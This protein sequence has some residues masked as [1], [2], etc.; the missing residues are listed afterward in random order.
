MV[1]AM[2]ITSILVFVLALGVVALMGSEPLKI[3]EPAPDF[4][5]KDLNGKSVK[6]SDFKGKYVVLEWINPN[7]PFVVRHYEKDGMGALQEEI[8]KNDVVWLTINS[9]N[10]SHKDYE[11]PERLSEIYAKWK[12]KAASNLMDSDGAVGKKYDAKT[13]PHM[14]VIGKDGKLLYQGAIDDDP[15]GNKDSRI[16]Y[17]RAALNEAMKGRKIVN[18]TTTP[19]GCSVKY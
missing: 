3:G 12:S 14:Y 19:Y 10:P 17:V 8:A 13:T 9:T 1:K 18:T 6:L 4:E 2:R 5:L 15:R 16:Q 11:T 7:C